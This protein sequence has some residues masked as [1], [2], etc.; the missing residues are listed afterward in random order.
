MIEPRYVGEILGGARVLG[1]R[2]T[3]L[4]ELNNAVERGLPKS[5]LRNVARRV[6]PGTTEQRAMMHR[7]V[8]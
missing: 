8:P 5:T 2:V 6:F 7:I 4:A 3:S 1:R